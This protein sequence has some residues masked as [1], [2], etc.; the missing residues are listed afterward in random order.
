MK[1]GRDPIRLSG[2]VAAIATPNL[3]G[4][5][6]PDY[7]GLLELLD[8]VADGGVDS[9]C[10]MGSTGEFLNYT[11]GDRQRA[12]YLAAKRSRLPLIVGVGH[13]TFRGALELAEDAIGNGASAILLMP[14]YFYPYQQ[15]EVE[16]FCRL[17][18]EEVGSDLPILLYNI[19]QFT[20]PIAFE[21]ARRLLD[22]GRFA[23]IKDSSGDWDN[24][25]QLLSL[26]ADRSFAL[27]AGN[28]AIALRAVQAGADG[29][30]SG[31]AA[32]IPEVLSGLYN[33]ARSG[34]AGA[35]ERWQARLNEF[36][37]WIER[38]PAP[39]GIKRALQVRKQ[40]GGEPAVPLSPQNA[41]LLE[42]F[43]AWFA[44]WIKTALR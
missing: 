13:S 24:F 42:E 17:F 31:C 37:A 28:D 25:A 20:S 6:E 35:A 9:I 19:P 22:T 30:L 39:V 33:A 16:A 8:F 14:P 11:I 18:A 21:T 10:L 36:I 29:V 44:G 26:K 43:A 7:S 15:S 4:T 1:K 5:L 2:V 40:K 12:L 23:G 41:L 27:F 3:P 34:D 32:A 38:F